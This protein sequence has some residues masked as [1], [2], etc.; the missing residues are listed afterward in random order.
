MFMSYKPTITDPKAALLARISGHLGFGLGAFCLVY[1]L[2]L[3]W[4]MGGSSVDTNSGAQISHYAFME[5]F[6]DH[7][8]THEQALQYCWNL[9]LVIGV[10]VALF[11]TTTIP[12]I[13]HALFQLN[14]RRY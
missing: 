3:F 11:P 9:S 6:V 12:Y 8:V 4:L 2:G 14:R 13:A 1:V 5:K 10:I 7:P